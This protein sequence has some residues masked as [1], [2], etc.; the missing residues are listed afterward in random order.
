MDSSAPKK[1]K[2]VG[3]CDVCPYKESCNEFTEGQDCVIISKD[4]P[5]L[6]TAEE[7]KRLQKTLLSEALM[8]LRK[9][10][11]LARAGKLEFDAVDKLR[12]QVFQFSQMLLKSLGTGEEVRTSGVDKFLT[13][14]HD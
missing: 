9:A 7:I 14:L 8:T 10:E 5:V 13:G 3:E 4:V 1:Q 11:V 6:E 12:N 2:L